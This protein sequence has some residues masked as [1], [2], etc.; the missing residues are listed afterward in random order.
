MAAG[1]AARSI[2]KPGRS[3]GGPEGLPATMVDGSSMT[4]D[5]D[6]KLDLVLRQQKTIH[7]EPRALKATAATKA[8]MLDLASARFRRCYRSPSRSPTQRCSA[9]ARR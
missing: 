2:L 6:I 3:G 8:D 4:D 7:G 9:P 5:A 1:D